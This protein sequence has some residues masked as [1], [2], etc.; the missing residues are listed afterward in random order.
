[1]AVTKQSIAE[2]S[3]EYFEYRLG[4]AINCMAAGA[5]DAAIAHFAHLQRVAERDMD[6][7]AQAKVLAILADDVTVAHGLKLINQTVAS[8]TQRTLAMAALGSA[9]SEQLAALRQRLTDNPALSNA[10]AALALCP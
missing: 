7:E 8:R 5:Y 2:C 1:L 10:A 4:L 6:V 9:T 3:F